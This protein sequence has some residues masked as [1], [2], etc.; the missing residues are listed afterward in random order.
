MNYLRK[1]DCPTGLPW[2]GLPLLLSIWL[3][4][5]AEKLPKT[6]D[7]TLDP[8]VPQMLRAH[9]QDSRHIHKAQVSR[10]CRPVQD[11]PHLRLVR[12]VQV[13]VQ[14]PFKQGAALLFFKPHIDQ[15]FFYALN[16][17]KHSAA[18][19]PCDLSLIMQKSVPYGDTY[20]FEY[21]S[22]SIIFN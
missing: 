11:K 14:R 5:P 21:P 16:E 20:P 19:L 18:F 12:E 9:P 2:S 7:G 6:P 22:V 17:L 4:V 15:S 10:S 3:A 1:T 8:P 13:A